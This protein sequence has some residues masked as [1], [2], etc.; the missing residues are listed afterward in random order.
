MLHFWPIGLTSAAESYVSIK[1][2]EEF[3][4]L[5]EGKS[6]RDYKKSTNQL[7]P[8]LKQKL[9]NKN[10]SGKEQFNIAFVSDDATEIQKNVNKIT[11][12]SNTDNIQKGVTMKNVTA[13]WNK[14]LE[15]LRNGLENI[16]LQIGV[17][18]LC[19]IVG[20]VGSGKSTVLQTIL[21]ELEIDKGEL[22]VNGVVSYA[23]QEPWLFEGTVRQNI[24]FTEIYDEKR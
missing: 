23:A 13:K 11:I 22:M 10:D 4:L 14:E 7:L 8:M 5:P 9:N 2:I 21:G 3:L 19:A 16:D 20:T 18:P 1:R 6:S 24:L 12:R 17:Q 15:G